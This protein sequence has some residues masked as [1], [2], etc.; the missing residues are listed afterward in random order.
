M[1]VST[2]TMAALLSFET[3]V[4][5]CFTLYVLYFAVPYM[6]R[7]FVSCTCRFQISAR[8]MSLEV[9]LGVP[10]ICEVSRTVSGES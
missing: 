3:S 7:G 5:T 10:C 4:V 8:G 2:L 6:A 1:A 9:P